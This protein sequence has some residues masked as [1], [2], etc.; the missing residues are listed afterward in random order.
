M[1]FYLVGSIALNGFDPVHSDIDFVAV[2][3]RKACPGDLEKLKK[4]HQTL[5]RQYPAWKM[6]GMYLLPGDLGRFEAAVDSYP[7]CQDGRVVL[8]C[9]HGLNAANAWVLKNDAVV[10]LGS[11]PETLPFSVDCE[12]VRVWMKTNLN[13]YWADWTRRPAR[14]LTLS[15]DWGFQWAVLGA[16]RQYYSLREN[17]ITTKTKAGEYALCYLPVCWH[18][19]I[20]EALQLRE[21]PQKFY[22]R[23]RVV[24]TIEA[25]RFL[26]Y[27][28]QNQPP[29]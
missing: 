3:T 15:L 22:Y 29:L 18:P 26:K 1:G 4:I 16:L 7:S 10:V 5:E 24:R 13:T 21:K 8:S 20:R 27:M 28:L 2:S 19:L 25:V 17:Q 6:D 9:H 14:I 11:R 23:F 12:G